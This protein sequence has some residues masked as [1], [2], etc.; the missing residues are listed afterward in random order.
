MYKTMDSIRKD[1]FLFWIS[2]FLSKGNE[3]S[4]E[5]TFGGQKFQQEIIK[6]TQRVLN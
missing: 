4:K 2:T 1:D 3:E 6:S 5:V